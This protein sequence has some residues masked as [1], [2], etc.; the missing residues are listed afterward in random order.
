MSDNRKNKYVKY[1]ILGLNKYPHTKRLLAF[2][3]KQKKK[4]SQVM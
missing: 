4:L 3:Q 1:N 2:E